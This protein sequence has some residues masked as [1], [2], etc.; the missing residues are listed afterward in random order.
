MSY[1]I[2]KIKGNILEI[3]VAGRIT[4]EDEIN[5]LKEIEK[6]IKLKTKIKLLVHLEKEISVE[7]KAV[8]EDLKGFFKFG[9]QIEK[10]AFVSNR[11]VWEVATTLTKPLTFAKHIQ[12]K[13]FLEDDLNQ[14]W[15][16]IEAF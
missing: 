2:L 1:K 12:T 5:L 11:K 16:W 13:F 6:E 8:F 15:E 3:D 4:L 9:D 10:V 7:I 14:A